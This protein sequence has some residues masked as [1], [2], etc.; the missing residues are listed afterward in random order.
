MV[1]WSSPKKDDSQLLSLTPRRDE[2]SLESDNSNMKGIYITSS[3]P[4]PANALQ[5]QNLAGL[6][7]SKVIVTSLERLLIGL[8]DLIVRKS[9]HVFQL[10]ALFSLISSSHITFLLFFV[11]VFLFCY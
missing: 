11:I 1:S 3:S 10:D 6:F 9:S 8:R 4:F 5:P 2:K 7:I